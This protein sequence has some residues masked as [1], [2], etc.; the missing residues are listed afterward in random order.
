M[1]C[2]GVPPGT[3]R[4]DAFHEIIASSRSREL[5]GAALAGDEY[6]RGTLKRREENS[7]IDVNADVVLGHPLST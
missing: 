4:L 6:A 1:P 3:K 2:Q 7:E 5:S